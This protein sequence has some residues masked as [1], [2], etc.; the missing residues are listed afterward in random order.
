MA[1]VAVI[2]SGCGYLDGAEIRESVL[3]LLALDRNG[4]NVSIFAPDSDQTDVVNHLTG[5]PS[6]ETRNVLVESARIARGKIAPLT[7]LDTN[8]FDALVLPGGYGVAK[9]L[10]NL[11]FEGSNAT[12][13]PTFT[14]IIKS[15]LDQKKPI[16]AICISPAVLVAATKD[17]I[18]PTVTIGDDNDGLITIMGATHETCDTSGC[19][20]DDA[21]KIASCSAYM[22]EDS[23]ANVA[24]GIDKVINKVL[25]FANA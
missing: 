3:A 21:H 11:A 24:D 14:N 4:A 22:R 16:G 2:L 6:E 23:I 8:N 1:N 9:N 13:D 19:V 10:S 7:E 12:V 17:T 20:I 5:Q 25:D 18:K 15:F